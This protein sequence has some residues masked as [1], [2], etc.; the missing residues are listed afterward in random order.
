MR[1]NGLEVMTRND[2]GKSNE[3]SGL[4]TRR[5]LLLEERRAVLDGCEGC[6]RWLEW[7]D[8]GRELN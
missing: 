4:D 7:M 8:V 1:E 2:D 5:I 3:S 6:S